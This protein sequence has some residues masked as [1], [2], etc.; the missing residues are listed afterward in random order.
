LKI[1]ETH[2]LTHFENAFS[3]MPKFSQKKKEKKKRSKGV[4][5]IVHSL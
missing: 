1:E 5:K 2:I 4:Q 3:Q